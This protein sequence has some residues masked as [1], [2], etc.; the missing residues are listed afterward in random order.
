MRLPLL[1]CVILAACTSTLAQGPEM[2]FGEPSRQTRVLHSLLREDGRLLQLTHDFGEGVVLR[3]FE[4]GG[5][6]AAV[7]R[8]IP[9]AGRYPRLVIDDD[10]KILVVSYERQDRPI[11]ARVHVATIADDCASILATRADPLPT[12]GLN[13][14]WAISGML[15]TASGG[16]ATVLRDSVWTLLTYDYEDGGVTETS[17]FA[18]LGYSS[19][20]KFVA[21]D[22]IYFYAAAQTVC[23]RHG[24][25]GNYFA[26]PLDGSSY[27][28]EVFRDGEVFATGSSSIVNN[29]Y[30]EAPVRSAADRV[31]GGVATLEVSLPRRPAYRRSFDADVD[32]IL[33]FAIVESQVSEL[34]LAT[35]TDPGAPLQVVRLSLGQWLRDTV[36]LPPGYVAAE[37]STGGFVFDR[38]GGDYSF[39]LYQRGSDRPVVNYRGTLRGAG[40][41]LAPYEPQGQRPMGSAEYPRQVFWVGDDD[42]AIVVADGIAFL[43]DTRGGTVLREIALPNAHTVSLYHTTQRLPTARQLVPRGDVYVPLEVARAPDIGYYRIDAATGALDSVVVTLPS[44]VSRSPGSVCVTSE[45]NVAYLA[46]VYAETHD[47]YL[48]R[49]QGRAAALTFEGTATSEVA[50]YFTTTFLTDV[51]RDGDVVVATTTAY[52]DSESCLGGPF[53]GAGEPYVHTFDAATGDARG[54]LQLLSPYGS[55]PLNPILPNASNASVGYPRLR[56]RGDGEYLLTRDAAT[57]VYFE[58]IVDAD[59]QL[60]ELYGVPGT[61]RSRFFASEAGYDELTVNAPAGELRRYERRGGGLSYTTTA[62]LSVDELLSSAESYDVAEGSGH[63]VGVGRRA[64]TDPAWVGGGSPVIDYQIWLRSPT[65]NAAV[66]STSDGGDSLGDGWRVFPS[67]AQAYVYIRASEHGAGVD[68]SAGRPIGLLDARGRTVREVASDPAGDVR[69]DVRD[70]PAGLYVVVLPDGSR[71]RVVCAGR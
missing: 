18:Q 21:S 69:L 62:V 38:A 68:D 65:V 30:E 40:T 20:P 29:V 14:H 50:S 31:V 64:Y 61:W 26:Y 35:T 32:D 22:S 46:D 13:T 4:T 49:V 2:V 17:V 11:G 47:V 41:T 60:L 36:A 25:S 57:L 54:S 55:G 51:L 43:V 28:P 27:Y 6:L 7:L 12:S 9:A 63:L 70:L 45:G 24:H 53:I 39:F 34:F 71:R 44:G 10:G 1:Y 33:R 52:Q 58:A 66:T 59:A 56:A 48:Y 37:T 42:R 23:T 16:Y 5:T 15:F 3:Q 67:P 19:M 8:G